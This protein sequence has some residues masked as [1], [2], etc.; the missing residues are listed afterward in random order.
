LSIVVAR[1]TEN[2]NDPGDVRRRLSYAANGR[3][4]SIGSVRVAR[5]VSINAAKA[6]TAAASFGPRLICGGILLGVELDLVVNCKSY[7]FGAPP[8]MT[9]PSLGSK[10]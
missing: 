7:V 3:S 1:R 2:G 5:Q 9:P 10:E 4:V 6:R 8:P